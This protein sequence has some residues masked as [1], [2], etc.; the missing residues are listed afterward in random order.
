MERSFGRE[1]DCYTEKHHIIPKCMGGD[2]NKRNLAILT[3]EEHYVAHQLLT[4]IYP[5]NIKLI[6]ATTMMCAS[7]RYNN[8][9]YGWLRRRFGESQK[10]KFISEETRQK[11]SKAN[12]GNVCSD[13]TRKKLSELKRGELHNMFGVP[14]SQETRQKISDANKGKVLSAETRQKMSNSGKGRKHS[15]ESKLKMSSAQTGKIHSEEHRQNNSEARK[16]KKLSD[17]TKLKMSKAAKGRVVSTET[18]EKISASNMGKRGIKMS[19]ETIIK[20]EETKRRNRLFAMGSES[21]PQNR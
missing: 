12:M 16:G 20:R 8:K 15:D 14:R 9:L 10:G 13:E 18:R 6:Y 11:I 2:N 7:K 19:P 21:I 5:S 3:P 1:L 17:E 4:K